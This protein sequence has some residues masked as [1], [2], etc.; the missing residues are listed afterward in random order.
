VELVG[1]VRWVGRTVS[2]KLL[3]V[4]TEGLVDLV[5]FLVLLGGGYR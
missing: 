4:D 5:D 1:L 3:D 2:G